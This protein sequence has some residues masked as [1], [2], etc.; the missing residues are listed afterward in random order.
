MEDKNKL[1][2]TLTSL[3]IENN[4]WSIDARVHDYE[5]WKYPVYWNTRIS[6]ERLRSHLEII[7]NE[8]IR[9][10]LLNYPDLKD[11]WVNQVINLDLYPIEDS[12]YSRLKYFL[13][14]D[15]KRTYEKNPNL[16]MLVVWFTRKTKDWPIIIR[17]VQV[18]KNPEIE[19]N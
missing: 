19:K 17:N 5:K 15:D 10:F 13:I 18:I 6:L 11:L 16:Y 3:F 7:Q 4:S 2:D 12:I 14:N 9:Y 8:I 1:Y